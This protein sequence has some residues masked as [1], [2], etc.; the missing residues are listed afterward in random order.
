MPENAINVKVSPPNQL[1]KPRHPQK[2]SPLILSISPLDSDQEPVEI[3][4]PIA[5]GAGNVW[6]K[7]RESA[8]NSSSSVGDQFDNSQETNPPLNADDKKDS[9][10]SQYSKQSNIGS[11][12]SKLQKS[13]ITP[14]IIIGLQEL[15][16]SATEAH[17]K[18]GSDSKENNSGLENPHSTHNSNETNLDVE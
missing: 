8:S 12:E 5:I 4:N 18:R 10:P 11:K 13:A 1:M 15:G 3:S 17:S 14:P 9:P 2:T 7:S 16:R 6:T